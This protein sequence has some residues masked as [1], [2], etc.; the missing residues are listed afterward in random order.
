MKQKPTRK[1]LIYIT[2]AAWV[3]ILIP[4]LAAMWAYA[5]I[6]PNS[7]YILDKES[8]QRAKVGIVLGAGV[9]SENKPFKELTARLD[10]AARELQA[11]R[12]E[13]LILSGD[14]RF[15]SYNE[16]DAMKRYLIEEKGIPAGKLQPDYAGRSTYESCERA[17][18][19][20]GLTET[21]LFSAESHLPRAIYLCR[22]FG[23]ESYGVASN[24]EANNHARR[25]ALARVKA[26][27][28][29]Y[30]KGEPTV[31]G[32]HIDVL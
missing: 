21:I 29:I 16:P 15:K 19:I 3:I 6:S 18:K 9:N 12:V 10:V 2:V 24:V 26:L 30:I 7:K 22:Q 4:V 5:L 13:K 27:V 31:L 25:E 11:G 14:N 28:N 23:I 20:F 32:D 1:S 17:S 8:S